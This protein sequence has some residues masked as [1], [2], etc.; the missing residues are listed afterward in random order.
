MWDWHAER[1]KR[2]C[3]RIPALPDAQ[4]PAIRSAY[5][6]LPLGLR[7]VL[8]VGGGRGRW[9]RLLGDPGDYTIVDVIAPEHLA[10]EPAS[11]YV[12]GDAAAL[13]FASGTFGFVL[14]IEVLQHLP[15]PQYALAEAR[16]VLAP[17]GL[18][19]VTT[20]QAWPTHG[21]PN[22]YFRYTR[23]GLEHMLQAVGLR[24]QHLIPLGGPAS[25][26][27]VSLEND[28][29]LLR[30]PFVKQL[31]GYPLWRFAALLDRT[32]FHDNLTGPSPDASG[33]LVIANAADGRDARPDNDIEN[34]MGSFA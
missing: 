7:S 32:V 21:A 16:R 12:M 13:P 3:R 33:W 24:P 11:T 19:V 1:E 23:Y 17:A 30:K 34:Q 9:R 10:L 2:F 29:P 4:A 25:V 14:M 20:R 5:E 8:D 22:D 26:L 15:E 27:T 28:V 6:S 31:V 18:V